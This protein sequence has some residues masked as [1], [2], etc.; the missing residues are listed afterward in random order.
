MQNLLHKQEFEKSSE[1]LV[2]AILLCKHD[3]P[4]VYESQR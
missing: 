1:S 4:I 2:V 3:E